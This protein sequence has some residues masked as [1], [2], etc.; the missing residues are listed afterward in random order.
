MQRFENRTANVTVATRSI[1]ASHACG[2]AAEGASIMVAARG[3]GGHVSLPA[4]PN[5]RPL[6]S[7]LALRTNG[8]K[9]ARQERGPAF[10]NW[11]FDPT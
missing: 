9:P 7:H 1:G 2:F 3:E 4:R 6:R 8:L 10:E 11:N 5:R